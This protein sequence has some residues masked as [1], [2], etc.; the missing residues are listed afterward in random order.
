[1][2]DQL[3]PQ[4]LLGNGDLDLVFEFRQVRNRG[5]RLN[6]LFTFRAQLFNLRLV[7]TFGI[8][9]LNGRR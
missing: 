6:E 7:R 8:F 3:D 2:L 9:G 1:L 5:N 4:S